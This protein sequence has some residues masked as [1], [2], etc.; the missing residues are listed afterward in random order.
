MHCERFK[1]LF[2][3]PIEPRPTTSR[4]G[5]YFSETDL[6]WALRKL[7]CSDHKIGQCVNAIGTLRRA[8]TLIKETL[9]EQ[10]DM[11]VA[12]TDELMCF[13]S[14][15]VNFMREND[16]DVTSFLLAQA[17]TKRVWNQH[18]LDYCDI[19]NMHARFKKDLDDDRSEEDQNYRKGKDNGTLNVSYKVDSKD[20]PTL[21]ANKAL[22]G[23][24]FD[25]WYQIFYA[26]MSQAQVSK[27]MEENFV[28]C[29]VLFLRS[30][31]HTV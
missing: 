22:K 16:G 5:E 27:L 29:C 31:V 6:E 17:F 13:K 19:E 18:A 21:Q 14:W 3:D 23:Q 28:V 12:M 7:E 25:D 2:S 8:L 15:H 30:V 1:N 4:S 9:Q 20:I 26:K 24:I 10:S 11:T